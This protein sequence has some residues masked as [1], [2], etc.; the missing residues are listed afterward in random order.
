MLHII[1]ISACA[2]AGAIVYRV[3]R[4]CVMRER[5]RTRPLAR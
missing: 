2:L 4:R 1:A 3:A 5:I